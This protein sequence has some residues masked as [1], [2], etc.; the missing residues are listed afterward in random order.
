MTYG[1]DPLLYLSRGRVYA[2]SD[3]LRRPRHGKMVFRLN[4]RTEMNL[5]YF[6]PQPE[7]APKD[8]I[9]T[10]PQ[11]VQLI[12]WWQPWLGLA[13]WVIV[14][15]IARGYDLGPGVSAGRAHW[16]REK[17]RATIPQD[18]QVQKA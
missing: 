2:E 4:G 1:P 18:H 7:L 14:L 9:L 5:I 8:V 16:I 13:D 15:R 10:E 12:D 11:I 17:R 3:G 6:A